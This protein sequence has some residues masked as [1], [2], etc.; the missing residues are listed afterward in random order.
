MDGLT[1]H[2]R[3][4]MLIIRYALPC[5]RLFKILA[6]LTAVSDMSKW[7]K[8]VLG[9][10]GGLA[11]VAV[12]FL[13][14][15]YDFLVEN[16]P[17]LPEGMKTSLIFGYA[18]LTPILV[19]LGGLV[20]W[21]SD[22]AK[23]MKLLALAVA[24]PALITT[25]SGGVKVDEI[26]T[27][28]N[29]FINSAY[30]DEK[31]DKDKTGYKV[32]DESI[33]TKEKTTTTRIKEGVGLFFGYGKVQQRYWVIV[34]SYKKKQ[35]ARDFVDKINEEDGSLQAFVGIKVPPN[36]Y[37]PVIVGEYSSLAEAQKLRDQA[38]KTE[39]ITDAFL[40]VGAVR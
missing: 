33:L 30:A 9:C 25:W 24:A 13:G 21:V 17:S 31:I 2:L 3:W 8:L 35:D 14:Q 19:F 20:A 10:A 7:E 38:L 26:R 22:E 16:I 6:E 32:L 23:R 4:L 29:F 34:G 1:N 15:D 36:E 5:A 37:Y 40:S 39:A 28:S 11:A 27:S 12:K 18:I